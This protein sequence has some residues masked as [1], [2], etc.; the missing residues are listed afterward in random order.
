MALTLETGWV[1]REDPA[2][3]GCA[4]E[5]LF[6]ASSVREIYERV[7]PS[8]HKFTVP[9]LFDKVS[10]TIVSNESAD[11]TR[12]FNSSFNA[13][14]KHPDLDLFPE[15]LRAEIEGLNAWIYEDINNGVYRCGFAKKQA[16]CTRSGGGV[17]ERRSAR[18]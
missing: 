1:F 2:F 7:D 17:E 9:I 4:D 8:A 13:I 11:I 14:A 16:P 5:P 10:R 6:G 3:P 18:L 15:D 12:M